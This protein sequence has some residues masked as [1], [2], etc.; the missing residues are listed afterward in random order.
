MLFKELIIVLSLALIFLGLASVVGYAIYRLIRYRKIGVPLAIIASLAV[1]P[2]SIV[3]TSAVLADDIELN[4][5][6][7]STEQ[8]VGIYTYGAHSIALYPDGTYAAIGFTELAAGTWTH[9]DWNLTLS[10][11]MLAE[12]RIVTRNGILCIAPHYAGVDPP[13]GILLEKVTDHPSK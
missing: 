7:K 13:M 11:S 5:R 3:I 4:P 1:L 10:H 12:P 2:L 8:L 6:I 9:H